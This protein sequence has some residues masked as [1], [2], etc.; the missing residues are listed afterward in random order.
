MDITHSILSNRESALLTGDY[1]TYHAQLSRQLRSVRKRVGWTTSSKNTK[2]VQRPDI[3]AED[4]G[5]NKE[6]VTLLLLTAERAR[7]HA[8]QLKAQKA[9]DNSGKGP[10]GSARSH[11]ISRLN[12]AAKCA[13]NLTLLLHDRGATKSTDEDVLEAEACV[14]MLKGEE[15]FEKQSQGSRDRDAQGSRERWQ[16]CL[17][18]FSAA[19][20]IYNALFK[21]TKNE[22]FKELIANTIDPSL[23]YASYRAHGTRKTAVAAVARRYFPADNEQLLGLIEKLDSD[24]L[25]DPRELA[26]RTSTENFPTNISWRGREAN[27]TDASIGQALATVQ[28]EAAK[29]KSAL[30]DLMQSSNKERGAAYDDILIANQDA[31]DTVRHAIEELEKE[32]VDEGDTRMQDL[33]VTSLAINYDL[34]GWRVGRNRMLIG[35][36]DGLKMEGEKARR[37]RRPR[38]DGKEWVEKP[39]GTGRALARFRE[40]VVLYNGILQSIDS[41]KELRGAA[42]DQ[43]FLKELEGQLAYFRALKCL[44][45]AY[46]HSLQSATTNALALLSQAKD[47]STN[48]SSTVSSS[49]SESDVPKLSFTSQQS[50]SLQSHLQSL[51][52]RFHSLADIQDRLETEAAEANKA[53]TAAPPVIERLAAYP[54]GGP[55]VNQMVEYPPKLSPVP[56]KPLY[57]DLAWNYIHYPGQG[58]EVAAAAA[59]VE[60]AGEEETEAEEPKPAKRGWFGF[61]RA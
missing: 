26:G 39:E 40:R 21:S 18:H 20:V 51:V 32:G 33:R 49:L 12:K 59:P 57:L 29:L 23:E 54:P 19:R 25:K 37:P 45:I 27:I 16:T 43:T 22:Q 58:E 38:K 28:S 6:F 11:I 44:N 36:D 41:V 55:D 61:G 31:A 56:V 17:T 48:A 9:T 35:L 30:A 50:T 1:G 13:N 3:T 4:I 46:A 53:R 52:L 60:E 10:T 2:Y 15:E 24:A 8:M 7:A 42:R 47:L 5:G 14:L 34:I